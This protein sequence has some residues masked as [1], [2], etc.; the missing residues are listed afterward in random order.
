MPGFLSILVGLCVTLGFIL[1]FASAQYKKPRVW[2][3][4]GS[5]MLAIPAASL[6][7]LFV[8]VQLARRHGVSRFYNWPFGGAN[9]SDA[10]IGLSA[11]FWVLVWFVLLFAVSNLLPVNKSARRPQ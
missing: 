1:I 8:G 4:I 11:T 6:T 3:G 10:Y 5:A 9:I 7:Y 2:R